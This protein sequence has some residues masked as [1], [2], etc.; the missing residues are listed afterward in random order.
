MSA[1]TLN[2]SVVRKAQVFLPYRGVWYADVWLASPDVLSGA[3]T[4][5]LGGLELKGTI[6]TGDAFQGAAD[7]RIV[8]GAGGWTKDLP[9]KGYANV[10]GLKLSTIASDAA[11]EAGETLVIQST[12]NRDLGPGFAR[13]RGQAS[14]VLDV[15]DA[16]WWVD[17]SGVTQ[18]G[19]RP[20]ATVTS[21]LEV[22]HYEPR[23]RMATVATE[24]PEALV[25]GATVS[26]T[27]APEMTIGQIVYRLE[28]GSIRTELWAA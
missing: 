17:T 19:T 26:L 14:D 15:L 24:T 9:P 23:D 18:V 27:G 4:L 25:V 13:M 6:L 7:Y 3:A 11:K 12:A 5:V 1:S 8:G 28:E 21:V 2:G 20:P 22:V 10:S 16:D